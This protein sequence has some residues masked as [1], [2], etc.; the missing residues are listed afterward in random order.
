MKTI[1]KV[2]IERIHVSGVGGAPLDAA[3]LRIA[4]QAAVAGALANAPLPSG[5]TAKALEL[6]RPGALSGQSDV[7]L[8]M[9]A[10]VRQ[11]LA[12]KLAAA[13]GGRHG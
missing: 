11:A 1:W 10:A 9:A 3:E 5:R 2:N 7:A 12:P 6:A 13:H 8:A 4:V